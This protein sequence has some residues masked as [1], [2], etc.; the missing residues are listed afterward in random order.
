MMKVNIRHIRNFLSNYHSQ[1][2]KRGNFITSQPLR[3]CI[4]NSIVFALYYHHLVCSC[5]LLV[6][7]LPPPNAATAGLFCDAA[8][9]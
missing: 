3:Q 1:T 5:K 9:N 6:N 8:A 7:S 4:Y 2:N